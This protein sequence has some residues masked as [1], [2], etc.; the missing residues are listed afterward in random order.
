M[1]NYAQRN[2]I[3]A[4][5][6]ALASAGKLTETCAPQGLTAGDV[7]DLL[8][9]LHGLD[10]P[11]ARPYYVVR[12]W[13][14]QMTAADKAAFRAVQDADIQALFECLQPAPAASSH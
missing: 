5:L 11:L 7:D 4:W 6:D 13:M 1:I 8:E 2:D 12:R 3:N 14:L 10:L 9:N